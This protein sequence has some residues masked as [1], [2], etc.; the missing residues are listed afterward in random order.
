MDE[1][2]THGN[3]DTVIIILANKSDLTTEREIS[4]EEIKNKINN[5]YKYF[6][7]SAK[8]GNNISLAFDEMKKL[9]MQKI[10]KNEEIENN[11]KS[12]KKKLSKEEKKRA[13]SL[14]E[15]KETVNKQESKCC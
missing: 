9:I 4:E 10:K 13:Q 8:T 7:V 11:L 1:L 2:K 12:G 5:K 3:D 15:I 6:E 14:D